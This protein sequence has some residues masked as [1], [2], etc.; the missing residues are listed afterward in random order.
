MITVMKPEIL[1]TKTNLK[2]QIKTDKRPNKD[3]I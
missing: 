2:K 1:K 3:P